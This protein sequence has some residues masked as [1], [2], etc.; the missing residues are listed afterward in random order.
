[1]K[2]GQNQNFPDRLRDENRLREKIR[3]PLKDISLANPAEHRAAEEWLYQKF[4]FGWSRPT[5]PRAFAGPHHFS[6]QRPAVKPH[7]AKPLSRQQRVSLRYHPEFSAGDYSRLSFGHLPVSPE[8]K[9]LICLDD[10]ALYFYRSGT[11]ACIYEVHLQKYARGFRAQAAWANRGFIKQNEWNSSGYAG[12]LLAYL[13]QSLLLGQSLPFP[14][15]AKA[16]NPLERSILRLGLMG[17]KAGQNES[18]A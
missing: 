14:Y 1:M 9:W 2:T 10:Q 8:D 13:V 11:R 4:L 7:D 16:K 18:P 6:R 12:R 3:K 5:E 17:E 15:P